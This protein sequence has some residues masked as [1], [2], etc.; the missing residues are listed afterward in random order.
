MIVRSITLF[1][2][3][4]NRGAACSRCGMNAVTAPSASRFSDWRIWVGFFGVVA[5][6]S[7]GIG[8]TPLMTTAAMAARDLN[9]AQIGL[10]FSFDLFANALVTI[11]VSQR[12]AKFS[13]SPTTTGSVTCSSGPST[14]S[15]PCPAT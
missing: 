2:A 12:L 5:P 14:C 7:A 15:A 10:A 11:W 8:L 3:L 4:A 9:E 6:S 13:P 1:A